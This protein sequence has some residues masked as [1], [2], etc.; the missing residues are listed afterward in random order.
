MSYQK[1]ITANKIATVGVAILFAV[2][3]FVFFSAESGVQAYA[4][5]SAYSDVLD[6][7]GK[8]KNFNKSDAFFDSLGSVFNVIQ[9]AESTGGE[10]FVYV[11]Q[12]LEDRYKASSINISTTIKDS[13]KY[14]EYKL[15]LL[16]SNGKFFK[17][18]ADGFEVRTEALRYYDI[19]SIYTDDKSLVGDVGNGNTVSEKAYPVGQLWTAVTVNG[20]VSYSCEEIDVINMTDQMVK[21]RRL[22]NGLSWSG[23]E[24]C[25]AHFIAF[26]CDHEIDKLLSADVMFY[27]QSYQDRDGKRTFKDDK[28]KQFKTV[29]AEQKGDNNKQ[30]WQRLSGMREFIS[31]NNITGE[32]KTSLEHYDWIINFYETEYIMAE[33]P[34]NIITVVGI[35]NKISSLVNGDLS[36]NYNISAVAVT[37]VTLM[38]LEF[39][40]A[41]DTYNLGVV[42]DKQSGGLDPINFGSG[43]EGWKI[44]LAVIALIVIVVVVYKVILLIAVALG[45]KK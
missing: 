10:L 4:A 45:Y 3:C 19:S 8:D 16:N 7:L 17:Y 12:T 23:I 40:Y 22:S 32:I 29:T 28:T 9:I 6:D 25:D 24:A 5:E 11:Y 21:F 14:E 13:L 31:D 35:Y 26:S 15:T 2:L 1:R 42:S 43:V 39:E 30:T 37:D 27:T 36:Y 41:G 20:E 38:R 18:R 33:K 34:E 44:V